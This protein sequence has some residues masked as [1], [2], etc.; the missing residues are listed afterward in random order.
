MTARTYLHLFQYC[1]PPVPRR[2]CASRAASMDEPGALVASVPRR[3]H[4]RWSLDDSGA[5]CV[6][7]AASTNSVLSPQPFGEIRSSSLVFFA[8]VQRAYAHARARTQN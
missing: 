6:S 3:V 1:D 4:Q 7:G 2:P 5:V 8:Y